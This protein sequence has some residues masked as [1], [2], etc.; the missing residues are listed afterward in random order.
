MPSQDLP[1]SSVIDW[2]FSPAINRRGQATQSDDSDISH[3][4]CVLSKAAGLINGVSKQAQVVVL[5]ATGIDEDIIWAWANVLAHQIQHPTHP[6]VVIWAYNSKADAREDQTPWRDIRPTMKSIFSNGGTIIVSSGNRPLTDRSR[7]AVDTF[8]ALWSNGNFSLIVAG[9]VNDYGRESKFSQGRD[10][11]T[12]WAPGEN[13]QC[14]KRGDFRRRHTGTSLSTGMVSQSKSCDANRVPLIVRAKVAGLVA[15]WIGRE[16]VP[17]TADMEFAYSM[18]R[19][20]TTK[21]SS[22]VRQ[23]GGPLMI[24]DA[25]DGTAALPF[26]NTGNIS[27]VR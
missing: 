25:E 4:S 6:A 12:V 15:Y 27:N 23:E 18:R 24:W 14:S 9:S 8:P 13:V 7:Q 11:V 3:G 2:R 16:T 26:L 10:H 21:V 17:W 1:A 22:W 20:L 19:Y 5:K